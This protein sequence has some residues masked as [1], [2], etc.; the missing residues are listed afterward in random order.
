[1]LALMQKLHCRKFSQP[2]RVVSDLIHNE[3]LVTFGIL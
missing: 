1:M 2:E 3:A